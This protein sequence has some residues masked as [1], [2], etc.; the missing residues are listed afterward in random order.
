MTGGT[1]E[2]Y[3][4]AVDRNEFFFQGIQFTLLLIVLLHAVSVVAAGNAA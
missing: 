2:L 3:K 4:I 1:H